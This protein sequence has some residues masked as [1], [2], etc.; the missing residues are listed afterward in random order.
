MYYYIMNCHGHSLLN[1]KL[2]HNYKGKYNIIHF[3][4]EMERNA[5]DGDSVASCEIPARMSKTDVPVVIYLD[6]DHHFDKK[7]M[8]G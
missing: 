5:N 1:F 4:S 3:S 2:K 6:I 8:K 7:E